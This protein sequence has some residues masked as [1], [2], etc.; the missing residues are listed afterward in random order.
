MM[1]L[2]TVTSLNDPLWL[3]TKF[4]NCMILQCATAKKKPQQKKNPYQY[5]S[6]IICMEG[7][8]TKML[9]K[10]KDAAPSETVSAH[11]YH[12]RQDF[13]AVLPQNCM[14]IPFVVGVYL[15]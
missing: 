3:R 12:L 14:R 5:F 7:C 9:D 6:I 15:S 1:R 8:G 2:K 10:I 11:K 13:A 4:N